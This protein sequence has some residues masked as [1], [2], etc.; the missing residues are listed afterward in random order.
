MRWWFCE[1]FYQHWISVQWWQQRNQ[2]WPLYQALL[3]TNADAD[4]LEVLAASAAMR[5]HLNILQQDQVWTLR[6]NDYSEQDVTI[7]IGT[8]GALLCEWPEIVPQ[9]WETS[10]IDT[11]SDVNQGLDSSLD[12]NTP[13]LL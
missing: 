9:N 2:S 7:V 6:R 3:D 12:Q 4:G 5:M 8:E 13:A 11:S 1:H 10:G